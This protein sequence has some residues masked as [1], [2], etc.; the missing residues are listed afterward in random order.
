MFITA[1]KLAASEFTL[2]P[3]QTWRSAQTNAAYPIKWRVKI[4]SRGIELDLA[5][6]MENQELITN[7]STG[8][9]YWE[10]AI[11]IAGMRDGRAVKG[12]GYLEMTGYAGAAMGTVFE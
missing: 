4:P 11:V 6:T 1:T 2:E 3:L 8:V 7:E 10:G 5:A 12:R 9:S